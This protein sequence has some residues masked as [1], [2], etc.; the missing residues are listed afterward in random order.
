M[1]YADV[2]VDISHEKLDRSFQYLVPGELERE[3]RVGM[4]AAIPFGNGNRERKGYIVGLSQKPRYDPAKLKPLYRLC[5]GEETTESRLV[6]LAAWMR[7]RYGSTM[8]Q[9]LKTV[10]PEKG[11]GKGKTIPVPEYRERRGG[12]TGGE[13]GKKTLQSKSASCSGADVGVSDG[14]YK[15]V[16]GTGN[17]SRRS[18]ASRRAGSCK[19]KSK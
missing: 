11:Q 17:D 7:E 19:N 16:R 13:P 18:E 10:S 1:I 4:V 5:S 6:S 8:A 9:A 12:K 3:I 14:L 15:G 2:I